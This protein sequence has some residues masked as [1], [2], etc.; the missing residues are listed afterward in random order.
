M[1]FTVN[2]WYAVLSG[3]IDGVLVAKAPLVFIA[4][5][6]IIALL[7]LFDIVKVPEG[8]RYASLSALGLIVVLYVLGKLVVR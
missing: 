8:W 7:A 1:K 2:D 3:I 4:K 6:I 5:N